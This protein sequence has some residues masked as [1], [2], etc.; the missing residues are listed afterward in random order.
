VTAPWPNS[1]GVKPPD[2]LRIRSGTR[3]IAIRV[4]RRKLHAGR[5]LNAYTSFFDASTVTPDVKRTLTI[6][7]GFSNTLAS[8]NDPKA[9]MYEFNENAF[10]YITMIQPRLDSVE[11]W[12]IVNLNNDEHP[13]HIH[14]NDFQVQQVVDP[15][16]GTT[17]GVQ[18]WG[19]DNANVPYP[20]MDAAGN[21]ITP[22]S[23]TLRTKFVQYTGTY[24][25]HCHRLNHEDN[26][27]MAIINVIPA[28]ST[29]AV[30]VPGSPGV[31]ASVNVYDGN[32]DRLLRSVTPFPGFEG[33]PTVTMGDVNGD[34]VL[35]LVVGAG[36][37]AAPEVVAYSG[38]ASGATS[39]FETELTRFTAFEAGF[40]GGV[41]VAT[42]NISAQGLAD[43]IIVGSGPGIRAQVNIYSSYLPTDTGTTPDLFSTVVPYADSKTGV[44]VAAGM[45]DAMSGRASIITVPGPGS[46]ANVKTFRY[47]LYTVN[48]PSASANASGNHTGYD[49]TAPVPVLTSEFMAFDPSYMGGVSLTTG[50]VAGAE[51]GAQSIILGM[52]GAPGT[53]RT[54]SAG[55]ALDA[56]PALY[57]LSPSDHSEHVTFAQTSE[58]T[59]FA[60]SAAGGVRVA[61]TSTVY[62]ADLLVSG[63]SADGTLAEV[64]IYSL[65]RA[66]KT[67]TTLTPTLLRL[68]ASIPGS[69]LA[70]VG[71]D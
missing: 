7:G 20:T 18:M 15:T 13:M 4:L 46:P 36:A 23:L 8:N 64:R 3:E 60:G 25:I 65:S 68:V 38:A 53:V 30:A 56:G 51:G 41:D 35:D 57:L 22:G 34:Q 55:S 62:G 48:D 45:V 47:D 14:V 70:S 26:G 2:R 66:N 58:F 16:A 54:F 67:A 44:S 32:G 29:Y 6:S 71:G 10:P 61:T 37:G 28:V 9:F 12:N 33:T 42:A 40:R 31:S 52:L 5:Q 1:T 39:V 11:E 43:N 59:P 50:W 21:V 27:L 49:S 17:T 63:L 19:Q 69:R 24:V